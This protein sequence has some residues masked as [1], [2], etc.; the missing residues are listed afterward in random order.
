MFK[1]LGTYRAGK[2]YTQMSFL[3]FKSFF[4]IERTSL[5]T[6]QKLRAIGSLVGGEDTPAQSDLVQAQKLFSQLAPDERKV[7]MAKELQFKISKFR[8]RLRP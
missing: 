6:L 3:L 8:T 7:P 1:Y 2:V 4:Q 5:V